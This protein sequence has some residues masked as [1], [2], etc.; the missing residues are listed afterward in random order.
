MPD[1]L[2]VGICVR[3]FTPVSKYEYVIIC[4]PM[5]AKRLA[6]WRNGRRWARRFLRAQRKGPPGDRE[7][8]ALDAGQIGLVLDKL[9]AFYLRG[10][11]EDRIRFVFLKERRTR[12]FICSMKAFI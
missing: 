1:R 12:E 5:A 7:E 6:E 9:Q 4:Y 3:L 8:G 11:R 2:N 10:N